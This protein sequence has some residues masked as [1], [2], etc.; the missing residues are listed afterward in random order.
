MSTA[1]T[2]HRLTA[3]LTGGSAGIGYELARELAA[4][5]HDLVLVARRQD[6]LEA[7]AGTLEGKYGVRVITIPSDLADPDSPQRIF[8]AV[9]AEGIQIDILVNNAGFGLGGE[10]ADTDIDRELDMVQVNV[11]AL[12][13]LTKLF[14]QPMILRKSGRI[15]NLGSTA[16]FQPGPLNS[17][18]YA[19]KA[20]VLSFSQAIDEE[21]RKT[22]VT[23]TCLC[24]GPVET[25]FA[26]VAGLNETRLF[27]LAAIANAEDVARFG[28]LQMMRG[29]RIAVFGPANKLMVQAQRFLPR[30]LVTRV[31]RKVQENR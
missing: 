15:L 8:D 4:H 22:G 11:S 23:V 25:E 9:R 13:H 2:K 16:A 19:T 28:Y 5:G 31:A 17:I 30:A 6:R 27:S 21:L 20:F 12:V 7:A 1:A 26:D 14:M 3:L 29:K 10:F 24:P 18:Y